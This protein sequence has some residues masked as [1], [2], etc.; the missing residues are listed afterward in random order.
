MKDSSEMDICA[1][2]EENCLRMES[3]IMVNLEMIKQMVTGASKTFME[4][5]TMETGMTIDSMVMEQRYGTV[6]QKLIPVSL[7]KE[8]RMAE[9]GSPGKME[10]TMKAT[11]LMV[12]SKELDSITSMIIKKH[13]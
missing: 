3:T 6:V 7:E 5:A 1:E 10:A 4:A 13:M 11:L 9:E 2:Q 12:C 8:R